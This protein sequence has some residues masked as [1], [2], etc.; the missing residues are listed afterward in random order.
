M[1][2]LG[3]QFLGM[4][5]EIENCM[6][7]RTKSP[8]VAGITLQ[9]RPVYPA[10]TKY[11]KFPRPTVRSSVRMTGADRQRTGDVQRLAVLAE[12]DGARSGL[13]TEMPLGGCEVGVRVKAEDCRVPRRTQHHLAGQL[14]GHLDRITATEE[15]ADEPL[16]AKVVDDFRA[17]GVLHPETVEVG[18]IAANRDLVM[19]MLAGDQH[20]GEAVDPRGRIL[21]QQSI[22]MTADSQASAPP[23]ADPAAGQRVPG[24]SACAPA[25]ATR[26]RRAASP[27][28]I[29]SARAICLGMRA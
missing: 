2:E 25:A 5:A 27:G 20:R 16:Q 13:R 10:A 9:R 3:D 21:V 7:R 15:V 24:A 8:V 11:S 12:G 26:T 18:E 6:K 14:D 4:F 22:G 28:L 29:P 23:W 17:E 19:P 1:G